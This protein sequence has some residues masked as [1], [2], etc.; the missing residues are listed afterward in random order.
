MMPAAM[1]HY[2]KKMAMIMT[3]FI[4]VIVIIIT[5]IIIALT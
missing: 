5:N 3:G 1:I 4:I 2:E